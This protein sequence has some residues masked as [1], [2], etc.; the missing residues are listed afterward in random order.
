MQTKYIAENLQDTDFKAV[1][2]ILREGGVVGF[3]TETVY[4]LGALFS[5]KKAL[6]K[7]AL[8]KKR[9]L[10]KAMTLHLGSFDQVLLFAD[11]GREVKKWFWLLA[12]NF[13]PGPL[14]VV[15][16]AKDPLAGFGPTVGVRIPDNALFL[17]L[18]KLINEPLAG[19]SANISSEPPLVSAED[20]F[21]EFQ[22]QIDAVVDGGVCVLKEASTVVDLSA[23]SPVMLREGAVK[24]A[25]IE[26]ALKKKLAFL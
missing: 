21:A 14:T 6:E 10:N 18:S 15:L 12:E 23:S 22:G 17:K 8:I 13:M 9:P 20:V 25:E 19:T 16:P 5:R 7:L 4:G 3:P 2:E 11:L 24:R 26:N 1:A